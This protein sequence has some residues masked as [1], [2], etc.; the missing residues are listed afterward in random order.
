MRLYPCDDSLYQ[1]F[2]LEWKFVDG[3]FMQLPH[4]LLDPSLCVVFRGVD[5]D[6]E[7]GTPIILKTCDGIADWRLCWSRDDADDDY[8]DEYRRRLRTCF[9]LETHL[10]AIKLENAPTTPY[11]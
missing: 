2:Q 11:M 6:V 9:V 10:F 3:K 4:P 7:P 5:A 1:Q 8:V